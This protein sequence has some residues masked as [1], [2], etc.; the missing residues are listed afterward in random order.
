MDFLT[1]AMINRLYSE[2]YDFDLQPPLLLSITNDDIIIT[3]TALLTQKCWLQL[4]GS[5]SPTSFFLHGRNLFGL[6]Q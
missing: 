3:A 2:R 5:L 4:A 6:H 1:I